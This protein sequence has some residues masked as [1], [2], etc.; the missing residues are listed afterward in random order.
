LPDTLRKA[1]FIVLTLTMFQHRRR[2]AAFGSDFPTGHDRIV[3]ARR[4]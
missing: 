2:Y 1:A 3:S 4:V